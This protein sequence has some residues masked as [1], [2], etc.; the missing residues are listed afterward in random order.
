MNRLRVN[1]SQFNRSQNFS[2]SHPPFQ[3]C[4]V[5]VSFVRER[6][7]LEKHGPN[8]NGVLKHDGSVL[9]LAV[10]PCLCPITLFVVNN[11]QS[12]EPIN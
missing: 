7:N 5:L 8:V 4:V 2:F 6:E 11:S 3:L 12:C 10:S 9:T 1:I